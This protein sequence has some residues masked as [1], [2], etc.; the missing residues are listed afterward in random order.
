MFKVGMVVTG[1]NFYDRTKSLKKIKNYLNEKQ[2]F[3]LKAPRRYGKSSL[4]EQSLLNINNNQIS[5]SLNLQSYPNM[6]ILID[7]ILDKF[8]EKFKIEGFMNKAKISIIELFDEIKNGLKIDTDFIKIS[9]ELATKKQQNQ[10]QRLL[11]TL[12]FIEQYAIKKDINIIIFF[13]EFQDIVNFDDKNILNSLRATVQLHKNITYIFAGSVEKIMNNIF[14]DNNSSF[15]KFCRIIELE[16]FDCDEIVPQIKKLFDSKNI[17]I[18]IKDIRYILDKLQGHPYNSAKT[19]QEI[20][21]LALEKDIKTITLND[22][23][24]GYNN[25]YEETKK[26]IISDLD[27]T[28]SYQGLYNLIYNVANG[29]DIKIPSA[30]KYI[31][32]QKLA[33]MALIK[34]QSRGEYYIPDGFMIRYLQEI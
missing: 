32:F 22:M 12:D 9:L 4:V 23:I 16:S 6:E 31:L 13:D 3:M 24:D 15:Y 29:N 21:F 7:S 33:N 34:K 26:L 27:K 25:A 18:E 28:K 11:K 30:S 1:E 2:H 17:K 14:I 10:T 5:L 20:Y 19:I 8:Y